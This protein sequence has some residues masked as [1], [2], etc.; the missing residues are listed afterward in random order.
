M[1]SDLWKEVLSPEN[2]YRRELI[3]QVVTALPECKSPL[4][5]SAAIQA[6]RTANLTCELIELLEKVVLDKSAFSGNFNLQNLLF[7]PAIQIDA[8]KVM[9]Y[10]H[11][12]DNF[13]GPV[14]GELAVEAEL[15]EEA[16]FIFK[17]FNLNVQAVCRSTG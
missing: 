9:D 10:I 7:L 17:K 14:I 4:Q 11:K 8:S 2:E 6:F 5:V 1:D 12:L 3:D 13:D 16:F 15:Y